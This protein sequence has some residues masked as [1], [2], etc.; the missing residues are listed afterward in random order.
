LD[1]SKI[2]TGEFMKII[3]ASDHAGFPIK[4]ALKNHPS[5]K[6]YSVVDGGTY[7]EGSCHYPTYAFS[8]GEAV[9]NQEVDFGII[10]CG[11]GIGI[12]IAANKVKGVRA[13]V[14]Y[15]DEAVRKSRE[16]NDANMIA[17]GSRY[18]QLEDMIRRIEI[19]LATPYLKGR[20][21]LRVDLI[22]EYEKKHF[23]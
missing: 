6:K 11:S 1:F 7:D 15:H 10:I 17:F 18:M 13:A 5:L 4:E 21:E 16:D 12:S 2:N 8:A 22:S 14:G 9:A 19:F 23:K 3:I 20:H